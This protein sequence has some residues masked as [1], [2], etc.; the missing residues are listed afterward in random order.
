MCYTLRWI[1]SID[2]HLDCGSWVAWPGCSC[3]LSVC[4]F[5]FSVLIFFFSLW[6]VLQ[7]N[8]MVGALCFWPFVF[9]WF[10]TENTTNL[11]VYLHIS[12]WSWILSYY[13]GVFVVKLLSYLFV[14]FQLPNLYL[15]FFLCRQ[16]I[17]VQF[18]S[19]SWR[20]L[21]ITW[22][23]SMGRNVCVFVQIGFMD[24][25]DELSLLVYF[26]NLDG[27]TFYALQIRELW[28]CLCG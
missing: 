14:D 11:F 3:T 13:V 4:P 26:I 7:L 6:N 21:P 1:V 28:A 25:F 18:V 8:W 24:L 17:T 9:R 16:D 27:S 10:W 23:I 2:L 5:L 15:S 12:I 22:I 20:I 19:V